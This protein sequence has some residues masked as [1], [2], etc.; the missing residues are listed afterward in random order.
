MRF[1][2]TDED[3]LADESASDRISSMASK[4]LDLA[5][6]ESECLMESLTALSAVMSLLISE[7]AT[8]REMAASAIS[9]IVDTMTSSIASNEADGNVNWNR[10]K[11]H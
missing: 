11:R 6:E 9:M 2:V 1:E 5:D 7:N 4:M 3:G 8:S 10:K